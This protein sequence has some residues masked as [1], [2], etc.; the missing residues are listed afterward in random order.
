MHLEV[1]QELFEK[2]QCRDN[3]TIALRKAKSLCKSGGLRKALTWHEVTVHTEGCKCGRQAFEGTCSDFS[4]EVLDKVEH[5][6]P[7]GDF[8]KRM[9]EA[10]REVNDSQWKT[11]TSNK[12]CTS[13]ASEFKACSQVKTDGSK[14]N[15]NT[16]RSHRQL[17]LQCQLTIQVQKEEWRFEKA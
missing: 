3:K 10:L 13:I 4:Y 2:I 11:G 8:F 14:R 5:E 6:N 15:I 12:G 7:E 17:K 16:T 9:D 1:L